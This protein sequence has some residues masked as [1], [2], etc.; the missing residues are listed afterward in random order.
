[1]PDRNE[2]VFQSNHQ[3]RYASAQQ[4]NID[5]QLRQLGATVTQIHGLLSYVRF[6]VG[7]HE[8]YYVYNLNANNEYYLQRIKPYPMSAGVFPD[9]DAIT[10]F[11]QMDL[12]AFQ[13]AMYSGHFAEFVE[14]NRRLIRLS[15][16]LED[17]FMHSNVPDDCFRD[18]N[19][20]LEALEA[21]LQDMSK[22]AKP[23]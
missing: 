12:R 17:A 4:D 5:M 15:Q 10:E 18:T 19:E 11:I 6:K 13:N 8:L 14:I 9:S 2:P 3:M 21:V 1:M 22:R 7:D 16:E 20:R 23:L